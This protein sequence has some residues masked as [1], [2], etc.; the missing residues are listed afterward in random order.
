MDD[1]EEGWNKGLIGLFIGLGIA[2]VL[3]LIK[4]LDEKN[5]EL[6]EIQTRKAISKPL[7]KSYN[8]V[9]NDAGLPISIETI[10]NDED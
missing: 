1:D 2:A 3:Y 8:I 6:I 4:K 5:K 7:F 10:R 9:R